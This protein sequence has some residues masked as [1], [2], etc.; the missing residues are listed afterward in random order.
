MNLRQGQWCPTFVR[1]QED[2]LKTGTMA[3]RV[4]TDQG[5]AFLKA[6]GNPEGPHVLICDLVATCLAAWF[7][8]R[9][10]EFGIIP[11]VADYGL[12]FLE[13]GQVEP[14]PA[15]LT[16]Y[17]PGDVWGGADRQAQATVKSG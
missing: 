8:L 17:D 9:T 12:T 5:S 10:F 13:G 4:E 7:G 15:F 16:R 2:A 6:I 14:G 11:V 3:I 1:K